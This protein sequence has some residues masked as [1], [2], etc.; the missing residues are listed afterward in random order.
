M[1]CCLQVNVGCWLKR[2]G[3]GTVIGCHL[4]LA[5]GFAKDL[6]AAVDQ[7]QLFQDKGIDV[8]MSLIPVVIKDK[9]KAGENARIAFKI[10]DSRLK[11][12]ITKAHPRAWLVKR[13]STK[14][15]NEISCG[16]KIKALVSGS[17]STRADVDLNSYLLVTLNHDKTVTFINPQVAF[18][19]T[20]LENIV[21]LP[22]IGTDWIQT[23]DKRFIIISIP[24]KSLL[25]VIEVASRKLLTTIPTGPDTKPTRL[26]I[27]PNGLYVWVSLDYGNEVIAVETAT[28]KVAARLTVEKG[29]HNLVVTRDN[30]FLAV[31]NSEADTVTV[32]DT[33]KLKTIASIRTGKTPIALSYG[34]A[35]RLVYIAALNSGEIS[36]IDPETQKV[37]AA[38]KSRPGI[39]ALAFEPKGRFGFAINQIDS[40][41][42]VLDS[43]TNKIIASAEVAK[44]PDQILFTEQYAY[45]R[46]IGTEK[47]SLL[48]L[49]NARKGK[50]Q[51]MEIQAGQSAPENAADQINYAPMMAMT[52]DEN[53][54]I[55]ANAPDRVLYYYQE[56]MMASM[57]TFS[58]YKRMPRGILVIDQSLNEVES[59]FYSTT[60]KIPASGEFD[61]PFL[62][63]QPRIMTC[64]RVSVGESA[65]PQQTIDKKSLDFKWVNK[66]GPIVVNQPVDLRFSLSNRKDQLPLL[67]QA[68]EIL[69]FH[70]PGFRQKHY[71]LTEIGDGF[72]KSRVDFPEAGRNKILF[73]IAAQKMSWSD[74]ASLD[75]DV[76]PK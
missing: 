37:V 64:F 73:R 18:S 68:I 45:I 48:D 76:K 52:P 21:E 12:P 58:N 29:L 38:V 34:A 8:N 74:T 28:N 60:V 33:Q 5:A 42:S 51:P 71:M 23:H 26:L 47:F 22:G 24:D 20:K 2:L 1:K 36:V 49:E 69:V 11:K 61:M 13:D 75:I 44:E 67:N 25:A 54:V 57:G 10:T 46:G 43:A 72:Y 66:D 4:I 19:A 7:I 55:I 50:L 16:H 31:S 59:G 70:P 63:D 17:L 27:Q 6:P 14:A 41:V 53:S 65:E 56:G 35:S 30:R 15:S 3:L 40:T 62:L 39:V 32:I 9:L